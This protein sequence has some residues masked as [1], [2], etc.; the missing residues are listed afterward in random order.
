MGIVFPMICRRADA[1]GA[2][3]AVRCPPEGQR[4]CGPFYAQ[5][6]WSL[7]MPEYIAAANA[8]VMAI[9]AIE[10]P[11]AV[12]TAERAILR[13]PV[14]LGGVARTPGQARR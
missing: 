12:D 3:R 6:R 1:E 7:P 13:S 11:R 14:A 4:L 9:A 2:V 10:H 8:G 5:M